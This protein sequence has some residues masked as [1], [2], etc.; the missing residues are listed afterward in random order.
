RCKWAECELQ[1][2]LD[3]IGE[4]KLQAQLL[5]KRNAK[6]YKLIAGE[7]AKRSYVKSPEQLRLKYQQL[8]RQ[9]AQAQAAGDGGSASLPHYAQLQ[10][11]LECDSSGGELY[12]GES[13]DSAEEPEEELD[14]AMGTESESEGA[15][16]ASMP[17]SAR[18]KWAEGEVDVFLELIT[19]LGLQSALLRKRNAKIFRLLS[20]E[21]AKRNYDK[22]P[23]KLR[24]KFQQLRRQYNKTK[25]GGGGGGGG[26]E[27]FEHYEAMDKLLN[28]AQ[29]QQMVDEA[30]L[31]SSSESDYIYSEAE[32]DGE[33][34]AVRR[35]K[36]VTYYWTD[37][38]VDAFLQIIKQ[39]NLFRALDGSKK[40]NFKTLAYISNILAKQSYKRTPHQLRNK[41]RLLLQRYRE[42]KDGVKNVRMQ[43]RHFDMLDDLMQKKRNA[44]ATTTT[45]T[46]ATET[47]TPSLH[48]AIKRSSSQTAL[49]ALDSDSDASSSASSCELLRVAAA[50]EEAEDT[51][52]MP[53]EPTP[54]E[55]LSSISEGQKQLLTLLSSSHENFLR[56]QR[57]MQAQFLQQMSSIMRQEREATFRMLRELIQPK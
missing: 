32:G 10:A 45:T 38:E 8:R 40:R 44:K 16:V 50:G 12:S 30:Q 37:H 18:C 26:G 52:E 53:A 51:F 24:I 25:N 22:P 1:A 36:A 15:L 56:Q 5:R 43:P 14:A 21:M 48:V 57:E 33:A 49:P 55:V 35:R 11:L 31:S 19:S 2:F 3:I 13:H 42:V 9:Y 4:L 46:A 7:M 29:Q 39:Q 47:E 54:L 17:S 34:E 23:E 6:V 28:P 27:C 41:L 20:K